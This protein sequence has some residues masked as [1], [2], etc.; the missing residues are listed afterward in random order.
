MSEPFFSVI[1]P[2]YNASGYI[3]KLLDSVS[4]QT[5]K[6]YELIVVCD[7]CTDDTFEIALE[8]MRKHTEDKLAKVDFGSDGLTRDRGIELA[9]GKWVLFADDDDWFPDSECF[10]SLAYF[11]NNSADDDTDLVAFGYY[12]RS[13]GY[14]P[15]SKDTLFVPRKDHVWSSAWRRDRIGDARFGNAVFCSDT[16]FIK[17]MKPRIQKPAF[18]DASLYYYNFLRPGSQTDLFCRGIIHESPVAE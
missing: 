1:I 9:T 6:D 8:Y 16:Y 13:M 11:I 2:A 10:F 5:F 15:P 4:K 14:I 3:R 18:L 12:K 17:A 7:S